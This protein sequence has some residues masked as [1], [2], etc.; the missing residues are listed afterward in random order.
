MTYRILLAFLLLVSVVSELPAT[1]VCLTTLPASLAFVPPA[2]YSERASV[3]NFWYGTTK[4]WTQLLINGTWNATENDG[5]HL[6]KLV[7]WRQG[8]DWRTERNPNLIV[9]ARRIDGEAPSVAVAHAEPV[10]VTTEHPAIMVGLT[11]PTP[12]CWN[13]N[14]YYAGVSLE[15]VVSVQV[16]GQ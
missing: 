15:F 6:T 13:V 1:G 7:F 11:I 16:N 14:A 2:P 10:F 8:F 4:L 12:G 9:T 5:S 3:G